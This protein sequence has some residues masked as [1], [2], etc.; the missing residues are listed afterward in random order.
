MRAST[1]PSASKAS[2]TSRRGTA[3]AV[4]SGFIDVP[5]AGVRRAAHSLGRRMRPPRPH[6]S[7]RRWPRSPSGGTAPPYALDCVAAR[8]QS[9]RSD[10]GPG[11][12]PANCMLP[13][14]G[15]THAPAQAVDTSPTRRTLPA[16]GTRGSAASEAVARVY[17][18]GPL[19]RP[20]CG[21]LPSDASPARCFSAGQPPGGKTAATSRLHVRADHSRGRAHSTPCAGSPADGVPPDCP[22]PQIA[23]RRRSRRLGGLNGLAAIVPARHRPVAKLPCPA[24]VG[25]SRER[26]AA[27]GLRIDSRG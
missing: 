24:Q 25:R 21:R 6:R 10:C 9:S 27:G 14:R 2:T 16:P 20:Q 7:G 23:G 3:A 8:F 12:C 17:R 13:A 15:P 19:F 4:Q 1:D 11:A 22:G 5:R 26:V 18:G